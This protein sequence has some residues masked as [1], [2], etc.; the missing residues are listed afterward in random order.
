MTLG[1]GGNMH[2]RHLKQIA[3]SLMVM[4]CFAGMA[5]AQPASRNR[6]FQIVEATIAD[7]HQAIKSKQLTATQLVNMYLARIKAYNGTCV[8]EPQGI[9]G[10]VSPIP[11]AGSHQRPDDA[12]SPARR[13]QEVGF[14]RSQSPQHDGLG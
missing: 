5:Q 1:Q 10:P 14:R 4:V 2:S 9:L 7:I 11:H 12:E 13:A 8:N 3:L 6:K